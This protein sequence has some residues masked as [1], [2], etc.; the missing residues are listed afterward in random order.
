MPKTRQRRFRAP[1]PVF[2]A[3]VAAG[4]PLLPGV[5]AWSRAAVPQPA[6]ASRPPAGHPP[7]RHVIEIML[8]NHTFDNLFGRFPGADGVPA[9]VKLPNPD[10]NYVAPPVSPAPAPANEGDTVDINHNRAAEIMMMDYRPPL[11]AGGRGYFR[12]FGP[13]NAFQPGAPGWKMNYYT[14]DPQNSLASITLFGPHNLPDEWFLARHFV[15]AD[16]NF[17]PA[18]GPTQPNRIYAVAAAADGWIS[19]SPPSQTL[20]IRTIFD[21]LSARGLSWRIYQGDYNGPPPAP[22]GQGFVTHW[23]PAWYTPILRNR[24]LW[25]HVR[26]TAALLPAIEGGHL[27]NFSFVVP[28][29][30]YSEHPPTDIRLGDAWLGQVVEAVMHSR[31]WDSTA[32]F[33]TYDEGGGYWDHVPPPLAFRYGYG[34]RTPLVIISPY[35]RPGVYSRTTTNISIL[36][37]MQHLW[38]L[39][40][41][42]ALNARSNDLM[43]A[44]DFRQRPLPPVSLPS[45]PP[46]TLEMAGPGENVVAVPG[47]P[48][49]LTMKAKTPGLV[50]DTTLTGPVIL[51]VTGPAGLKAPVSVPTSVGLQAGKGAFTAVFPVAGYYRITAQGPR[52]SRGWVTV[53]VG[54]GAGTAP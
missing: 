3:L 25:N 24:H 4:L 53:D 40:P 39:P 22:E 54:V 29:W 36:A 15:L 27:P 42:N 8:E 20:R 21:Q 38:G 2:G 52:G 12:G 23:N 31:Y 26:N 48:F 6:R 10:T 28:T 11:L 41:L 46:V 16:R 37:F 43:S 19:D 33:V 47:V 14:T 49:T 9:G 18:I 13:G 32:I 17:Q 34:T 1:A 50:T 5:P 35:V 45:V 7:I 30:L 44:F 51:T